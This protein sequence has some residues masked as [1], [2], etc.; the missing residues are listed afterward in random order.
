MHHHNKRNIRKRVNK[1]QPL[2]WSILLLEEYF[3]V[4]RNLCNCL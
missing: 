1:K 4:Q 2:A 3:R